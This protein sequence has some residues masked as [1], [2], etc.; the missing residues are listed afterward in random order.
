[1]DASQLPAIE[2]ALLTLRLCL[3]R[4]TIAGECQTDGQGQGILWLSLRDT[5]HQAPCPAAEQ[6]RLAETARSVHCNSLLT[7]L[8][9]TVISRVAVSKEDGDF[10][11]CQV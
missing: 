8:G 7:K 11:S 3:A 5:V 9:E 4:L 10:S 2:S 1:M 6:E